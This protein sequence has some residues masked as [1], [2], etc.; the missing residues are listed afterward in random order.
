M[1]LT[2]SLR[3]FSTRQKGISIGFNT[4]KTKTAGCICFDINWTSGKYLHSTEILTFAASKRKL[5]A[6]TDS[7]SVYLIVGGVKAIAKL[8]EGLRATPAKEVTIKEFDE[9]NI[10]GSTMGTSVRAAKAVS[11]AVSED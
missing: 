6:K 11:K 10:A 8:A 9:S 2:P 1:N 7:G 3:Y 5:F 4:A